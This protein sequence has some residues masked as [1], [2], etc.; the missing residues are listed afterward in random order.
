MDA[1]VPR[2]SGALGL[3]PLVVPLAI[4]IEAPLLALVYVQVD[5]HSPVVGWF[6]WLFALAFGLGLGWSVGTAGHLARCRN[7]GVLRFMGALAGVAGLYFSWGWF[8]C[9]LIQ[10]SGEPVDVVVL[11]LLSNPAR[12]WRIASAIAE[13]GWYEV[14]GLTPSGSALWILWIAEALIVVGFA[15]RQAGRAL[16]DHVYCE[17]CDRWCETDGVPRM[18]AVPAGKARSLV[19]EGD[20]GAIVTLASEVPDETDYLLLDLRRCARCSET[21]A[22]RLRRVAAYP[23]DEGRPKH[24][25]EVVLNY[26]LRRGKPKHHVEKFLDFASLGRAEI[27]RLTALPG[28]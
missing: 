13:T 14:R 1:Q 9:L 28:A 6:S 15:A 19:R 2:F 12:V 24:T 10:R 25:M 26:V 18:L 5:V 8:E 11:E 17:R 27:E 23:E 7:P 21:G 22:I 20:V 16:D 4:L 3:A